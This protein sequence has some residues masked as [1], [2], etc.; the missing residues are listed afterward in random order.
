VTL[1]VE[2]LGAVGT[3]LLDIVAT[4]DDPG[5]ASAGPRTSTLYAYG[6]TDEVPSTSENVE[7]LA[8]PWAASGT[9]LADGQ[10]TTAEAGPTDHRFRGP[11]VG[12]VADH[13]LTSPPLQ[14]AASG[15]FTF[16]FQTAWDFETDGTNF[17][18]GGVVEISTD[19]GVLWNDVGVGV[20]S[21]GYG[22]TLFVGS[23]NP[24]GGRGAYIA[25][26][27]GFPALTTVN[28]NL[29]TAYAGQTVRIRFRIASDVGVGASGWDIASLTFNNLTNQPFFDIGS[30]AVDCTPLA[31]DPG[32][33][34]AVAFAVTG[35]NPAMG[36][37]HFRYAL[38]SAA[39]VDVSIYDVSGRRV[40]TLAGGEQTAG[41]HV[42]AWTV[43]DDGSAPS[44]GVYFARFTTNGRAFNSRVVMM[45]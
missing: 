20:L 25:Q 30:N 24:L 5:L 2:L 44:S 7:T 11:D 4:Y 13:A 36:S 6:N 35:A 16:S 19:N 45:R 29:G 34:T 33:P 43:N 9:P 8:P 41:W 10:W 3:E 32:L 26:S 37:A 14:V 38:P 42:A 39:R 15:N 22:S 31:V 21:P 1:P 23:G 18:D 28:A 40:A 17:Y 12:E 27:P